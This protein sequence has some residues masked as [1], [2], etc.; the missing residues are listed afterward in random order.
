MIIIILGPESVRRWVNEVQEALKSKS[1]TAQ[2]HA[3]ILL[4]KIKQTDRLAISK[5]VQALC[6][7]PPKG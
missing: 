1:K 2:F 7:E 6:R 3:L 5:Q 4:N